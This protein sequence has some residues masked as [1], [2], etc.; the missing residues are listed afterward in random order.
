MAG[1][2]A[3]GASSDNGSGEEEGEVEEEVEQKRK[4][5]AERK[6]EEK[7]RDADDEREEDEEVDELD[8]GGVSDAAPAPKTKG[9]IFCISFEFALTAGRIRRLHTHRLASRPQPV[10]ATG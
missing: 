7:D 6:E 10:S 8:G 9:N 5:S 2:V 4:S 1:L 3:Y